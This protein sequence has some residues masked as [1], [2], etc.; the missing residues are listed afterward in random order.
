MIGQ[1]DEEAPLLPENA[2]KQVTPLPRFQFTL[3]LFLQLAE[4]LTTTTIYPFAPEVSILCFFF[5]RE[6]N[7]LLWTSK[8]IR[9]IGITHGEE[10]KVG[11]YVGL[12]VRCLTVLKSSWLIIHHYHDIAIIVFLYPGFHCIILESYIWP[13]RPKTRHFNRTFSAINL[14]VLLWFI[15]NFL[16]TSDEVRAQISR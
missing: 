9:N 4:H 12:L 2:K 1:I 15:Y 3:V 7:W 11:Y 14:N 16:G 8:L 6:V 13:Y 5:T 10:R